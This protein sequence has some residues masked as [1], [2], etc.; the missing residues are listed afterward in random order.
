MLK[1]KKSL[2]ITSFARLHFGFLDLNKENKKSFG[3]LGLSINKFKTVINISKYHKL[4]IKGNETKRA[5]GFVKKF[6]QKNKIKPDF[7]IN[8]IC[9]TPQHV[10]LGSGTQLALA[11]G[12][13][14]SKL[15]NLNINPLE[16]AKTM[17]RGNRSLIGTTSFIKGGFIIDKGFNEN[18]NPSFLSVNF[19]K[20]WRILLIKNNAKGLHGIEERKSFEKLLKTRKKKKKYK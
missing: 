1:K 18:K 19:P 14:I 8:I 5:L 17:D 7:S 20:K 6:C 16:I 9:S 4:D 11:I 12:V 3:G 10:G 15:N 13:G 2:Q